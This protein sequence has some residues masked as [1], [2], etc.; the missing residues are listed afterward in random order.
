[1]D[2]QT[3]ASSVEHLAA[4]SAVWKVGQLGCSMVA[5]LVDLWAFPMVACSAGQMA[6]CLV[7]QTV[8]CLVDRMVASWGNR[9]VEPTAACWVAHS[10]ARSVPSKADRLAAQ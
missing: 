2:G 10:V 6:G 9:K 1:M 5:H 3:A 4:Y 7:D 8:A